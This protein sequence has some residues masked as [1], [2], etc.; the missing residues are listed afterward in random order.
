MG[1]LSPETDPLELVFARLDEGSSSAGAGN[2]V[3]SAASP[4]ANGTGGNEIAPDPPASAKIDL[5]LE[6]AVSA[7][8]DRLVKPLQ[9]FYPQSRIDGVRSHLVATLSKRY[10]PTWREDDPLHGTGYRSLIC[11][12][13]VGL[14]PAMVVSARQN[15]VDPA[16]WMRSLAA[17]LRGE[18]SPLQEEWQAWCDPGLVMWRYGGWFWNDSEF[19]PVKSYRGQSSPPSDVEM[20]LTKRR[21]FTNHM[22]GAKPACGRRRRT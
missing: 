2:A 6:S 18:N 7:L 21:A 4:S 14:P 19:D 17:R 12:P 9:S 3:P 1:R 22:G 16:V 11:L 15:G 10:A 13:G 8:V 20:M 5:S